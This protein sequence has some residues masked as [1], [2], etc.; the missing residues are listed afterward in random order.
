MILASCMYCEYTA[1]LQD[2][3]CPDTH[4]VWFCVVVTL[5]VKQ[6]RKRAIHSVSCSHYLSAEKLT[7]VDHLIQNQYKTGSNKMIT[8]FYLSI[9][10]KIIKIYTP[11]YFSP[12]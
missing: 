5:R 2:S 9:F 4:L 10:L 7:R 3:I 1:N 11:S 12:L 8:Y 6:T